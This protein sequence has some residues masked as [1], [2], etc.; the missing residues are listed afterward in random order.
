MQYDI[1]YE[2]VNKFA[3]FM[4]K[5]FKFMWLIIMVSVIIISAVA[6]FLVAKGSILS[7]GEVKDSYV[8]GDSIEFSPKAFFSKVKPQYFIDGEWTAEAP[9]GIGSYKIRGV[10]RALFGKYNYTDEHVFEI[11]KRDVKIYPNSTPFIYG[12]NPTLTAENLASGHSVVCGGY[13]FESLVTSIPGWDDPVITVPD[14]SEF[15]TSIVTP[16]I[17]EIKIQDA[18]GNDVTDCYNI[19]V[20]GTEIDVL[21]RPLHVTVSDKSMVYNNTYLSFDGYKTDG[22]EAAGD[23]LV[24]VFYNT[25][26]DVGEVP[27]TPILKVINAENE[28]VS[29]YYNI[30]S[31]VGNLTVETRPLIITTY[32]ASRVYDGESLS[33]NKYDI[34]SELG[35]CEGH[36]LNLTFP[37]IT[38]VGTAENLPKYSITDA[39]GM[40]K[41]DNYSVFIA[42]GMLEIKKRTVYLETGSGKK[43]YDGLSLICEDYDIT[44]EYGICAGHTLN[45]TFPGYTKVQSWT[46]QPEFSVTNAVGKDVT[47]NYDFVFSFGTLE[48]TKRDITITTADGMWMYDSYDHENLQLD[49]STYIGFDFIDFEYVTTIKYAGEATNEILVGLYHKELGEYVNDCYNI[50][51]EYGTLKVTKRPITIITASDEKVYDGTPLGNNGYKIAGGYGLADKDDLYVFLASAITDVGSTT[52]YFLEYYI[53]NTGAED[54]SDETSDDNP[55]DKL[56]LTSD[57]LIDPNYLLM[58]SYD[59][60]LEYGTLTVLPREVHI[61]PA[62]ASKIY[63]GTPLEVSGFEYCESSPYEFVEGHRVS[64]T[65]TAML[66]NVGSVES[67]IMENSISVTDGYG[68]DVSSNYIIVADE[69]N[70]LEIFP[71]PITITTGSAQKDFDGAPLISNSFDIS[72]GSLV[73]GHTLGM[74]FTGSQTEV[75]AS[76]NSVENIVIWGLNSDQTRNYDITVEEGTLKITD[77]DFP[78]L[79]IT[80]VSLSKVYDGKYLYA[81]NAL[82]DIGLLAELLEQGYTYKVSV[83]GRQRD[84]G[85]SESRITYFRLYDESGN[86]VTSSFDVIYENGT[87]EVLED[88]VEIR[89]FLYELQK[90][91]DGTPLSFG[92][93]DYAIISIPDGCELSLSLNIS[94]TDV[95]E[96]SLDTINENIGAFATYTVYRD[97]VDVTEKYS[98]VFDV[99][100]GTSADYVPLKVSPRTIEITAGSSEKYYDGIA[101]TNGKYEI[102]RGTLADGHRLEVVISGAITEAGTT[103]NEIVSVEIVDIYTGKSVTSNYSIKTISGALTVLPK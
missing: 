82:E 38:K 15:Y 1:Y 91:Y 61:R 43:T 30:T 84:V 72:V 85:I 71:R 89:V 45:L 35:L 76:S 40:D 67:S 24:A 63:D 58:N 52:N 79:V 42:S 18:N 20:E 49:F 80:P 29:N 50:T 25:I 16:K 4:K 65:F 13:D 62:Y 87:L 22:N 74:T 60:T 44:G 26:I 8:Y 37:T 27:N 10:S 78:E 31:T 34:T 55:V 95:G 100:E 6:V 48:I 36:I 77:P 9:T 12:D 59:I 53:Y 81:Q 73:D 86:D 101:L 92:D 11:V 102:T 97:G 90:Y 69:T 19:T 17:N 28:D 70:I 75:G 39:W 51:Y 57:V 21:R 56:S 99:Y 14:T 88:V 32:D 23:T 3:G 98:L 46:N 93:D 103:V 2:K 33:Y 41:T 54:K 96:I 47:D 64:M 7:H 83:S 68:K 66:T 5:V 94:K